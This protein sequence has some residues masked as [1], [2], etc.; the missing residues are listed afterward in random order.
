MNMKHLEALQDDAAMAGEPSLPEPAISILR[1][2]L[3]TTPF[4]GHYWQAS[5]L[6][7]DALYL[8]LTFLIQH[9]QGY[10]LKVLRYS[11]TSC[12][13]SIYSITSS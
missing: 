4:T 5:F 3:N 6:K 2:N 8:H 11:L 10:A 1:I 7:L 9:H 12:I 13:S